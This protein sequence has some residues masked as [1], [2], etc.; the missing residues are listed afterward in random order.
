MILCRSLTYAQRAAQLL[1]RAGITAGVVKAPQSLSSRGCAYGVVLRKQEK[2]ALRLLEANK[3]P[4]G[5]VYRRS[6][7]GEYQEVT[8]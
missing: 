4:I 5:K 1:E 8:L 7:A 6:A 2:E 3:L